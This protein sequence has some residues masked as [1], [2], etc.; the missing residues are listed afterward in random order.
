LIAKEHLGGAPAWSLIVAAD[1]LGALAGAA[2]AL[3][4]RPYRP[5]LVATLAT[6]ALALPMLLLGLP[7]PAAA[8]AGGAFCAGVGSDVFGVLW[9][10]TVQREIPPAL[11]SRVS[12]YDWLGSVGL[13]PIGIAVAGPIAL[14]VGPRPAELGC[15]AVAV[16][17]TLLALGTR[18]VR[19][20]RDPA[21][22][23][24]KQEGPGRVAL[25]KEV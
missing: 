17:V 25:S 13:T 11:L 2:F 6:L 15:A 18:Q 23:I 4:L 24:R 19:E 7:V 8:V 5:L 14:A 10:T 22:A 20:L 3:R 1:G 9:D 12:S 16:V 21:A